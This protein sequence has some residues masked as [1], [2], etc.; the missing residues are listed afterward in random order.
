MRV[1]PHSQGFA[2]IRRLLRT[3]GLL[4]VENISTFLTV[5]RLLCLTSQAKAEK[6]KD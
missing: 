5:L 6:D 3:E 2:P 4:L 1:L